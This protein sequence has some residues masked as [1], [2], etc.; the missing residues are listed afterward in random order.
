MSKTV[1]SFCS[2]LPDMNLS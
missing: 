1:Y 2:L